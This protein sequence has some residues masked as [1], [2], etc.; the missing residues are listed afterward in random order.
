MALQKG[1][2]VQSCNSGGK[3]L[4]HLVKPVFWES[5]PFQ[6]GRNS[7]ILSL[8]GIVFGTRGLASLR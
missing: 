7:A 8:M 6:K 3:S 4:R 2:L 5:K 1:L